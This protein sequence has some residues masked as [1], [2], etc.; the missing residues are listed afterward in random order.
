MVPLSPV[1]AE[2]GDLFVAVCPRGRWWTTFIT[3][4]RAEAR[5]V[6]ISTEPRNGTVV[7][8]IFKRSEN[9]SRTTRAMAVCGASA[10]APVAEDKKD[11]ALL[12]KLE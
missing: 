8:F 3:R 11:A 5:A 12:Q 7:V 2:G 10:G 4:Q 1:A 9:D 6:T